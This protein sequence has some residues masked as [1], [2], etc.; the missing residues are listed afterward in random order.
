MAYK[1]IAKWPHPA[2]QLGTV[3]K[4]SEDTHPTKE[5]ADAICRMLR[6]KG[7]GGDGKIFPESTRVEHVELH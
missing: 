6:E 7:F 2:V 5:Q 3:S 1:S 4:E